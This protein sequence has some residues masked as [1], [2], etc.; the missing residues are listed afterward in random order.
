ML[1]GALEDNVLTLLVWSDEYAPELSLRIE[2]SI[3]ST[4]AH[5]RIADHAFKHLERYGKPAKAHI[6]DYIEDILNKRNSEAA[7]IEQI[8][9]A[10]DELA[11]DIQGPFVMEGLDTFVKTRKLTQAVENASDALAEG[12][13]ESAEEILHA[14][15][16]PQKSGRGTHLFNVDE[17]L[18]FLDEEEEDIFPFGIEALDR[19]RVQ[20]TRKSLSL[21]I[22]PA[23]RG[24]TW[25]LIHCGKEAMRRGRRVLHIT[26]EMSEK[27]TTARYVQ[28]IL[29]MSRG[30]AE[31]WRPI[32]IEQDADG[33]TKL[34]Y[35]DEEIMPHVLEAHNRG[36]ISKKLRRFKYRPHIVIKEFPTATL[37]IA[38]LVNY[39]DLLK[40][41]ENFEPD[42]LIVDYADLM[43]IDAASLRTDTGRLFRELRGVCVQRNMA[44]VTATQ[45]NRGSN[46]AK[47]VESDHVAEDWSKIATAD[48]ILTYSQTRQ[49]RDKGLA[50][51]YVAGARD[52]D[53]EFL[54][55]I[56]QNYQVGQFC[57]NSV[58]M[59][60]QVQQALNEFTGTPSD[61][62]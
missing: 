33:E 47:L 9:A 52:A 58:E 41:T 25:F 21:L 7:L 42:L 17:S 57:L 49:E 43:K 45:G 59:T 48:N 27:K 18:S 14:I 46:R 32:R 50:R 35:E 55:L 8:C 29:S 6:R 3:F 10:M 1:K 24:K 60:N 61:A 37:T 28:S 22:A 38:Q 36:L 44:G 62:D 15:E 30:K 5:R 56:T 12:N 39:L 53:G 40:R 51:L 13:L 16:M 20:P 54:A 23:K 34:Y 4:K 2:P 19:R 31:A 11:K 26:L